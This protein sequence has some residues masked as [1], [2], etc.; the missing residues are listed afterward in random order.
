MSANSHSVSHLVKSTI[1]FSGPIALDTFTLY[2]DPD[3]PGWLIGVEDEDVVSIEFSN[4]AL[5]M[6]AEVAKAW[7][8]NAVIRPMGDDE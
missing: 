1:K 4:A 3:F 6:K 2:T 5:V 8:D 7:L